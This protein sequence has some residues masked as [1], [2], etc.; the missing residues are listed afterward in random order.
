VTSGMILQIIRMWMLAP[1][2]PSTQP[3]QSSSSHPTARRR[4]DHWHPSFTARTSSSPHERSDMRVQR[5][6]ISL[7]SSGLLAG[8][9]RLNNG[10]TSW[11][12][13]VQYSVG[14][15]A[16]GVIRRREWRT[17][18]LIRPA[19]WWRS[20]RRRRGEWWITLTLIQPTDCGI[21]RSEHP[22]S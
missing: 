16:E 8:R 15:I 2:L 4:R 13:A 20:R 21:S 11:K 18:P 6:R 3:C 12:P 1:G 5:S 17:P 22:A 14:G 10:K 19:A 7:R 9:T